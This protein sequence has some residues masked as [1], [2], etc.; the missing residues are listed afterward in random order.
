MVTTPY[1]HPNAV[2]SVVHHISKCPSPCTNQWPNVRIMSMRPQ[3][4]YF[5]SCKYF[6]IKQHNPTSAISSQYFIRFEEVWVFRC[7]APLHLDGG[8]RGVSGWRLAIAPAGRG[9]FPRRL[10]K[11]GASISAS[12]SRPEGRG[13]PYGAEG[14][15]AQRTNSARRAPPGLFFLARGCSWG[16]TTFGLQARKNYPAEENLSS[17][18]HR[19]KEV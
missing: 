8:E 9:A 14:N 16:L 7:S 4:T 6:N 11:L 17:S 3:E 18:D 1:L 19:R 2:S 15:S 13:R 12:L 5:T 10:D